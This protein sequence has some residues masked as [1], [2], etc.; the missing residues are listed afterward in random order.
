[1][2]IYLEFVEFIWETAIKWT[3]AWKK[4]KV[5]LVQTKKNEKTKGTHQTLWPYEG[6]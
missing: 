5:L 1:M 3:E 2:H 4:V 6:G